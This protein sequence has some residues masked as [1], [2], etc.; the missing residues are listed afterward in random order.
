MQERILYLECPLC[1]SQNLKEHR[2]GDCSRHHSYQ[3]ALSKVVRWLTC[4]ECEH[5]FTE[6]YYREEALDLIFGTTQDIQIVG[7][8]IESQRHVSARMIEKCLPY[9]SAGSWLDV[10]YGNGSLLFTAQEYGFEVHGLELRESSIAAMSKYG[11][12]VTK[13][14]INELDSDRKFNVVS[15]MDVL[16]HMPFPRLGLMAAHRNLLPGGIL[17]LSMPNSESV[18]WQELDRNNVNPYWGEI[19][20]YHNF[21]RTTLYKALEEF[22]FSAVRYGVSERYRVCME[23]IARRN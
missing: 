1:T 8:Q 18:A 16:E 17:Y 4:I 9:V 10:G 20:H 5:V 14:D 15:M 7:N 3:P 11:I 12:G 23:V 22:G 6:G 21:S 19:E 13:A 2:I